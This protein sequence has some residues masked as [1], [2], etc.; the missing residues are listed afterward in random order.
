MLAKF[1]TSNSLF[2]S[3][4][5]W[6]LPSNTSKFFPTFPQSQGLLQGRATGLEATYDIAEFVSGLLETHRRSGRRVCWV[7]AQ[8]V[9]AHG[10]TA[11][12]PEDTRSGAAGA[13]TTTARSPSATRTRKLW[14]VLASV[15]L[16]T[17]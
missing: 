3:S 1:E 9:T 4:Y 5:T 6:T 17:T 10:V 14:P 16:R 11:H 12:E 2:G 8:E 15:W 7:T 13:L